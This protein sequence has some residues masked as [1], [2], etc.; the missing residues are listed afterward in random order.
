MVG[1]NASHNTVRTV[2]MNESIIGALNNIGTPVVIVASAAIALLI[3]KISTKLSFYGGVISLISVALYVPI[4]LYPKARDAFS[5]VETQI[6]PE[7]FGAYLSDM[8]GVDVSVITKRGDDIISE[9]EV[10]APE[11]NLFS[12]KNVSLERSVSG[13]SFDVAIGQINL[14]ILKDSEIESKGFVRREEKEIV[15]K[16]IV[17]SKRIYVGKSWS[18]QHTLAGK[19]TLKFKKTDR[20]NVVLKMH[21]SNYG[22]SQPETITLPNKQFDIMSFGGDYEVTVYIQAADFSVAGKEWASFTIIIQ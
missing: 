13:T 12:N 7:N 9:L 3:G 2:E 15:R 19:L 21:S 17:S 4:D 11:V 6:K 20:G 16:N 8:T 22:K 5:P 18:V 14:G 10:A 1:V